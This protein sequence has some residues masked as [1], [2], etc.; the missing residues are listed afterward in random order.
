[1]CSQFQVTLRR[2]GDAVALIGTL[3]FA[4]S[5]QVECLVADDSLILFFETSWP[6]FCGHS[7]G[8]LHHFDRFFEVADLL[9]RGFLK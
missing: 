5:K 1:M 6:G 2:T 7:L 8:F 3:K 9:K 4:F